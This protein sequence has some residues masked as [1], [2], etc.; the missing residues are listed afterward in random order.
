[1]DIRVQIAALRIEHPDPDEYDRGFNDAIRRALQV[2]DLAPARPAT[3]RW[4]F[5]HPSLTL[6]GNPTPANGSTNSARS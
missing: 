4:T 5:T 6:C 3:M 1:M 2:I